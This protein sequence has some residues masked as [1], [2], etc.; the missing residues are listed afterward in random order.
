MAS[1]KSKCACTRTTRRRVIEVADQAP[2]YH[3]PMRRAFSIVSIAARNATF[4]AR[5]SVWRSSSARSNALAVRSRSRAARAAR[6]SSSSS[7]LPRHRRRA[8]RTGGEGE[9]RTHGTLNT[10]ARFRGGCLQPLDHLSEAVGW[11]DPGVIPS[12]AC[13]R[14][15]RKNR[16]SC[17]A[18]SSSKT[19]GVTSSR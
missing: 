6:A 17:A 7:H 10:F 2:A 15:S 1:A 18:A 8:T 13:A 19:P 16:A 5:A 3:R 12:Y 9:I 11:D 4:P 14:R